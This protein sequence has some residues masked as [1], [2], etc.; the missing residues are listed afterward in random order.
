LKDHKIEYLQ[1]KFRNFHLYASIGVFSHGA[2]YQPH[3]FSCVRLDAFHMFPVFSF[4]HTDDKIPNA[5][6]ATAATIGN[7]I[8]DDD[9]EDNTTKELGSLYVYTEDFVKLI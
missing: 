3:T 9:D 5:A 6:A 1:H 7:N 8:D 4:Y 2:F